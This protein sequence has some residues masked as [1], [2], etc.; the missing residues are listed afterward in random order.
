MPDSDDAYVPS[1]ISQRVCGL[2]RTPTDAEEHVSEQNS[3]ERQRQERAEFVEAF[4][5]Q[6]WQPGQRPRLRV[7]VLAGGAA[8]IVAAGVAY[9]AGVLDSYDHRKAA[10]DRERKVALAAQTRQ[11][12]TPA[13]PPPYAVPGVT[14]TPT[15]VPAPASKPTLAPTSEP[16]EPRTK[17]K[18][19]VRVAEAPGARRP[20]SL[21]F[22]TARDLLLVNVMTGKCADLPG[23]GKGRLDGP[24]VQHTCRKTAKDNQR[25]DLV[26][27]K[28]T[29]PNGADLFTIRNSKD[30]LCAGP[31]AGATTGVVRLTEQHCGS[32]LWY[33]EEK[34][35]GQFWI[36]SRSAG[37]KCLDVEGARAEDASLTV[38]PCDPNDDHLWAFTPTS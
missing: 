7:R 27:K 9:G 12:L 11:A 8:V 5:K 21:K 17:K 3:T 19:T 1:S 6:A 36:H 33:L 32:R 15:P 13:S 10:K 20:T 26:V 16:A 24:V 22:S 28:G 2:R 23:N 18:G 4:N 34:H 14:T 31:P 37:G 25:W 35:S 29:G 38:W 30:G